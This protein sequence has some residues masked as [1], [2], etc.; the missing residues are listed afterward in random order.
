MAVDVRCSLDASGSSGGS[1]GRALS[2]HCEKRL[3]RELGVPARPLAL[4]A[5]SGSRF[6]VERCR[7]LEL[8]DGGRGRCPAVITL[9]TVGLNQL[10]VGRGFS[11]T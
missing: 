2:S 8:E 10:C 4:M 3:V 1:A 11:H 6:R 5:A 9:M 7:R